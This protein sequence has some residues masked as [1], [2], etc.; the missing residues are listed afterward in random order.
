MRILA[1]AFLKKCVSKAEAENENRQISLGIRRKNKIRLK[2]SN[3]QSEDISW[4]IPQ[5]MSF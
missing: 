3:F 2:N 5:K 4:S 1:E